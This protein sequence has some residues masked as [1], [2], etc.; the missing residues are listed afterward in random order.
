MM[1]LS[2]E[3]VGRIFQIVGEIS[4]VRTELPPPPPGFERDPR[5]Q[6]EVARVLRENLMQHE[7]SLRELGKILAE[8]VL[9]GFSS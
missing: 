3:Q 6:L 9:P 2:D 1:K 5:V 4:V 7:S 8:A